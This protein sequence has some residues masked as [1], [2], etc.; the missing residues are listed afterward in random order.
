MTQLEL[1]PHLSAPQK[2]RQEL[3]TALKKRR[4][5]LQ[6][7]VLRNEELKI[8]LDMLKR[9]Y[10]V[11]IGSLVVRDNH[12]DL[13]IIRLRN[14]IRL[15][16]EGKTEEEAAEELSSTFY[17]EQLELEAEEENIRRAEQILEKAQKNKAKEV[18]ISLKKLWRDLI[19]KF[20][21]DLTQ[22]PKEKKR[23]EEIMKQINLAYEE[24]DLTRLTKIERENTV[25]EETSSE[26]LEA[27]L[28]GIENEITQQEKH[29]SEMKQSEW[30][31]WHLK[32]SKSTQTM[33]DIFSEVEKNL[34]NDILTKI[35][36]VKELQQQIERL[37]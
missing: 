3:L 30:Y 24:G 12:L 2:K 18:S 14:M 26:E 10:M 5:V 23:R 28:V 16:E 37:K 31:K 21:P 11:K 36:I 1:I 32:I 4:K 25:L 29:F 13:D 7:L 15:M 9:E 22:D 8:R 20:H 33:D 17:A 19:S 34:L 6:K 27:L 35:K